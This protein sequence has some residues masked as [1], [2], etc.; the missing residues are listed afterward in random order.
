V[1]EA[2]SVWHERL[3]FIIE[4]WIVQSLAKSVSPDFAQKNSEHR[5]PQPFLALALLLIG[6]PG[7]FETGQSL[8]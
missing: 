8:V 5:P 2:C 6:H 7:F 1:F 4:A 3:I